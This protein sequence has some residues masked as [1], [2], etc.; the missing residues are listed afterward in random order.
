M[1]VYANRV[2]CRRV[3]VFRVLC[4]GGMGWQTKQMREADIDKAIETQSQYCSSIGRP[5]V[6]DNS[7]DLSRVKD[8]LETTVEMAEEMLKQSSD[9]WG[10]IRQAWW[11][12]TDVVVRRAFWS[13]EKR[14][15]FRR[16]VKVIGLMRAKKAD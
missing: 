3:A 1:F 9:S 15:S 14:D 11:D 6:P 2:L 10:E 7:W 13:R 5:N 8:E 4:E 16:V 12:L